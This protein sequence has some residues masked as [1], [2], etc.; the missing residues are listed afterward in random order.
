MRFGLFP[1]IYPS[2]SGVEKHSTP[3]ILN[4][5]E[6]WESVLIKESA[7]SYSFL[8]SPTI[9]GFSFS[10][11]RDRSAKIFKSLQ[12]EV[13]KGSY[14]KKR[15]HSETLKFYFCS[16]LRRFKES[17]TR[18]NFSIAHQYLSTTSEL[19]DIATQKG[20]NIFENGLLRELFEVKKP[21]GNSDVIYLFEVTE[22]TE[23]MD[24]SFEATSHIISFD[25]ALSTYIL[26]P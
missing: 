4:E 18:Y 26:L 21:F 19:P 8:H 15:I 16:K 6:P 2:S 24:G 13:A 12:K 14:L 5:L 23:Y 9:F 7:T 25:D 11:T 17:N 1:S 20:S 3:K 22:N 10:V